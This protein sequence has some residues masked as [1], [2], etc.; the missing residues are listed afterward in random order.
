MSINFG[1]LDHVEDF[2]NYFSSELNSGD[3]GEQSNVIE[4]DTAKVKDKKNFLYLMNITLIITFLLIVFAVLSISLFISNLLRNHLNKIKMNLGTYKAFGLSN[5]EVTKIYL[6]IMLRFIFSGIF[7]AL[8]LSW[9]LGIIINSFFKARFN[10]EELT[11]Y[12]I[13]IDISTGLLL[14]FIIAI[15]VLVSYF[16]INKILSKTPGDLIYNR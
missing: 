8:L 2:A 1:S 9:I 5:K 4:L 14:L 13:L 15:T 3:E 7:S 6:T 10:L 12:F 16:N 11:N